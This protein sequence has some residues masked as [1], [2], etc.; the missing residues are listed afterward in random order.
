MATKNYDSDFCGSLPLNH[1][2]LVQDYGYLVVIDKASLTIIQAS[3]NVQDIFGIPVNELSGRLLSDFLPPAEAEN[4]RAGF[5]KNVA[6]KIPV[7]LDFSGDERHSYI[8]LVH[9]RES[10]IVLELERAARHRSFTDVFQ[11]VKTIMAQINVADTINDVAE[12][13]VNEIKQISGFE[14]VMMYRFDDEW[15]GTVVAEAME[16]GMESYL[17]LKFP[18]SDVPKQARALY[19][20]NPYRLIPDRDYTPVRLYP[21]INPVTHTFTDLADCNLRGVASVHLEY[22]QNMGIRA[23]MSLRVMKNEQLWGLIS[24][25]HREARYLDYEHCGV[26]E[27]ISNVISSRISLLENRREFEFS[28]SLMDLK[29]QMIENIYASRSLAGSLIHHD[30]NIGRL[31]NG[32]GAALISNGRV[33]VIGDVPEKEDIH[34]LVYWLQNSSRESVYA[35]SNLPANYDQAAQFASKASGVLAIPLSVPKGE[36]VLVFRP[37]SVHTV[38]WGGN[39]DEAI[40]FEKDRSRYHPRNSFRSWQETVKET[41][42]PWH[43]EELE[44]AE[45]L[46]SFIFEFSAKYP[47]N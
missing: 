11:E 41:S 20:R 46:R 45:S 8:A 31:L 5:T 1:I 17:G 2:N 39:P 42:L 44:I 7:K 28:G 6:E 38:N 18:A 36:Y 3:E 10:Y 26:L 23:S 29:T 37:E 21:V 33:E 40:N 9:L 22:L 43:K 47:S 19:Q 30:L 12:L 24:C 35:D 13:A 16:E 15:N 14:K 34:N 25:H 27:L 32:T 4:L